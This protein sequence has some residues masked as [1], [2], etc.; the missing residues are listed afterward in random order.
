VHTRQWTLQKEEEE[1]TSIA[2]A[3]GDAAALLQP[4]PTDISRYRRH[5]EETMIMKVFKCFSLIQNW[6]QL[7]AAGRGGGYCRG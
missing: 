2:A 7:T 3:S 1:H 6:R 4:G 5:T